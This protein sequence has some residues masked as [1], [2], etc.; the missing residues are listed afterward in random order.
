MRQIGIITSSRADFGLFRP[1]IDAIVAAPDLE[2]LLFVTGTHLSMDFGLS[3]REIEVEN[4]AI[5]ER[6]EIPLD[7]DTP[8]GAARAMGMT[9]VAMA[10]AFS[11]HR[12]DI[13]VVLGDRFEMHAAALAAVP[14][15]IPI[16]HIH[17]G[18]LTYGAIDDSLRHSLTKFSHLHFA[19]T[20]DYARR[21]RQLGEE[22]W[23]ITV[24]G[25][26][27]LDNIPS[28]QEVPEDLAIRL[29]MTLSPAPLLVTVHPETRGSVSSE[30]LINAI[31]GALDRVDM[32]VVFTGTNADPGGAAIMTAIRAYA[33]SH[34][35]SNI[36][37]NLGTKYYFAAMRVAAAMVGNSSS[38]IVEAASFALPVVNVG[39][40]QDGRIRPANIIDVEI[41]PVA[42]EQAIIRAVDPLFRGQL[43]ALRNPSGDGHAADRII[44][45]LRDQPLDDALL[46]K[47]FADIA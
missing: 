44:E 27:G 19:S 40:R 42:V 30:T 21:L 23:R 5:A 35:K 26:P 9:T 25:A 15:N 1:I 36:V 17:G 28:H 33:A 38:G 13:L 45:K 18:E 43:T 46:V 31:L 22:D 7:T 14:F 39:T 47:R 11:R 4:Y 32:P 41:D 16:A 24:S 29:G 12:P 34:S 10:Q 20:D 37:D 2:L 8:L 6:V 3:V